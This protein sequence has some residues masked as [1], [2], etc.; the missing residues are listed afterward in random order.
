MT[1]L[2]NAIQH[3]L[4]GLRRYAAAL[5][6]DR[7]EGDW[8]IRV[9]L[10][11]LL[12]EP[13]RV[14]ADGDVKFQLYKLL[15]DVL[16]IDGPS[17]FDL[18]DEAAADE[19]DPSASFKRCVLALPIV[20]RQLFL[21]V[22]LEEFS[23]KRAADLVAVSKREAELHLLWARRQFKEFD[24]NVTA[25]A[26]DRFGFASYRHLAARDRGLRVTAR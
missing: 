3:M 13:A 1:P 18:A 10:E 15:G 2:A 17:S 11:A 6:G 9:A 21:L 22:S 12:Q 23:V 20:T 14:S 26:N 8:Y 24:A 4:P 16:A 19:N 25:A 7:R 5:T